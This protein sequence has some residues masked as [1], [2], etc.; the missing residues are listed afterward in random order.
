MFSPCLL[1]VESHHVG[2]VESGEVH[3][4]H[5]VD[6]LPEAFLAHLEIRSHE[7]TFGEYKIE[8]RSAP[9]ETKVQQCLVPNVL[10]EHLP[11]HSENLN[12]QPNE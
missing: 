8:T 7:N 12:L 6:R 10:H 4:L 9:K 3:G 1:A 11:G 5:A 2:V